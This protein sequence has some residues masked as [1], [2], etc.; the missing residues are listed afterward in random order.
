MSHD[1]T[2]AIMARGARKYTSG[3]AALY[4]GGLPILPLSFSS[5]TAD[6]A[7]CFETSPLVEVTDLAFVATTKAPVPVV[8]APV[9]IVPTDGITTP[10]VPADW[11]DMRATRVAVLYTKDW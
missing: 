2:M 7:A 6:L 1:F 10:V 4:G 3:V 8:A 11:S 9:R 5:R